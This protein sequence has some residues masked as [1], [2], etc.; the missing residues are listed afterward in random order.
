MAEFFVGELYNF[1][2]VFLVAQVAD[3]RQEVARIA[4]KGFLGVAPYG[5]DLVAL[6]HQEL[7]R[8]LSDA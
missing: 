7:D 8:C 5:Y 4:G 3:D 1:V 6:L 2:G